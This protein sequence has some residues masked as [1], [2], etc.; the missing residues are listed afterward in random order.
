MK[1]FTAAHAARESG[2]LKLA[3]GLYD[4]LGPGEL[5]RGHHGEGVATL[6]MMVMRLSISAIASLF[7]ELTIHTLS[8]SRKRIRWRAVGAIRQTQAA[9]VRIR[10]T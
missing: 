10:V 4:V 3:A 9:A 2:D 1:A 6:E 5:A 7:E 8:S